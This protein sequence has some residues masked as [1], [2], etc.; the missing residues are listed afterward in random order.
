MDVDESKCDGRRSSNRINT[1]GNRSAIILNNTAEEV[2]NI[3]RPGA[4]VIGNWFLCQPVVTADESTFIADSE[5]YKT[6]IANDDTLKTFQFVNSD[7]T[8]TRLANYASPSRCADIG[9][10]FPL[11]REGR[12]RITEQE[13][14][15][16]PGNEVL[17]CSTYDLL[18]ASVESFCDGCLKRRGPPDHRTK[19]ARSRQ[20]VDD[21][22]AGRRCTCVKADLL[23][24]IDDV[25]NSNFSGIR[26]IEFASGEPFVKEPRSACEGTCRSGPHKLCDFVRFYDPE[27]SRKDTKIQALPLQC[28]NDLTFKCVGRTMARR[29]EIPGHIGRRVMTLSNGR[30]P[31]R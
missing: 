15:G 9:W 5:L 26:H 22:V 6:C 27:K 10:F 17:S 14:G 4:D 2:S 8:N 28:E 23:F 12:L 20:I 3:L 25:H 19:S 16:R 24:F 1:T 31:R 21:L 29:Q 30:Q 11:D 7:R 13:K 18:R